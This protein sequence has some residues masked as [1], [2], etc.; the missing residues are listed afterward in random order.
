MYGDSTV[1][2]SNNDSCGA[3]R[4]QS[5]TNIA[6]ANH[7]LATAIRRL[8]TG[9]APAMALS[10][11]AASMFAI[12]HAYAETAASSSNDP[13][14]EVVV[15]GLRKS[16]QTSQELKQNSEVIQD[17]ISAVDIGALPDRSVT[18]AIQRIPG[19]TINHLFDPTD[20]NRFSAE[21]SGVAVRGMTQVRSELNGEDVFSARN[22][23]GLS[24]ED[25]PSELMAGVDVFKNP[26]ADMIEGGIGGTVNLRTRKPFDAKGLTG[27]VSASVNYGDFSKKT[28]PQAS[29]M[30]SDRW[31]TSIG[32]FG[33][34]LDVAYSDLATRTDSI[35]FGRPFRRK[36][37][38]VGATGMGV[39]G[40]QDMSNPGTTFECVFM[41][42]GARWSDLDFD[43]KRN[44]FDVALQWRPNDYI[45]T[46]LSVMQSDY[47][48][49][50]T[51]HSAW[52]QDGSWTPTLVPNTAATF[53]ANGVFRSGDLTTNSW[54]P[55]ND[56]VASI[57]GTPGNRIDTGATTRVAAQHQRTTNYS[58][59]IKINA[60]DR[61][62]LDGSV[63]YVNAT[64]HN[65]DYTVNTEV[66]PQSLQI[67]LSGD[68]PSIAAQPSDYLA[69]PA[70]YYWAAGMDDT[71][72]NRG[73]ELAA[74]LDLA[75]TLDTGWFKTLK[76]GLR[77]TNRGAENKDTG[78][79]W[80]QITEWWQG[81]ADG[82]WP[83][84]LATL[85]KYLTANS[86]YFQFSNFYRGK[87]NLPGGIWVANEDLV[88]NL[89]SNGA[90]IKQAE[91]QS[92]GWQ[93]DSFQ[94]G[95]TNI[96]HELTYAGYLLLKFGGDVGELPVDGN[97]G[98]RVVGTYYDASGAA[99]QPNWNDPTHIQF[100]GGA[101]VAQYGSG[102]WVPISF[103]SN[104]VD[105]LPS[106]NLR[107]K[108][109]DKLQWRFAA[110]KA[111]TRPS[112]D[113]LSANVQLNGNVQVTYNP[114]NSIA[115]ERVTGFTG[116]GGNPF[117][118]PMSAEQYDTALEWYFA[119]QGSLTG[120][121]F[122]KDLTNYFIRGTQSEP[123]FGTNW[124]VTTTV[125]GDHGV[126]KGF[127]LG[128]S[129]FYD[130]LPGFLKGLGAQANFTYIDSHGGSP[131]AGPT[132]DT[133]TVPPG[134]P[135]E[136]LSR[137]S[138]NLVAMYQRSIVEAR[139][140]YNWRKRWLLTT[141][142][143]DGKG[144]V[145]N[146]D[147][148]QLDGSL[149]FHLNS[150]LQIGLEANNLN[151]AKQKLLVG[152]FTYTTAWD[153]STPAYNV[154]YTDNRLYQNAWY[155]FDRRYALSIKYTF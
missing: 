10:G 152:P 138:Y 129:Q 82:T 149:F 58:W 65:T 28:K 78:Y 12:P 69:N 42:A 115:G 76:G 153:S 47:K 11:V 31:D 148:G 87:T 100:L 5:A 139:L 72:A 16:V 56:Y 143:G 141:H 108:F 85:D 64:A 119:P 142:D 122:Y 123:W 114:D 35:Q 97:I 121:A 43:R 133:A 79:N 117:L 60:T 63:V 45:E 81:D 40:C 136:G 118:K 88:K 86:T 26:S 144:S 83:G 151:N 113:Q 53:D 75:Y 68:L 73:S 147:F 98:M 90:I 110:S 6:H 89:D 34:L 22:T 150:H 21:G 27:G 96:Q 57:L 55:G 106:L 95:D 91:I 14:E 59:D 33:A 132:G 84:H 29:F 128:Y 9:A 41:P 52:F 18:E 51:E 112:F 44:G 7:R 127:E 109:T 77:F 67:D 61:L 30:I 103:K 125:N 120:T 107:I 32:E 134:L 37:S 49:D 93:P 39:Q 154:G 80:K 15:T 137:S 25:V 3:L 23:R 70:N 48:M 130:S 1:T 92:D 71:Q 140:A 38:D 24:F 20:T 62:S 116:T 8:F 146:D 131:T 145:W 54:V 19:V 46:S 94:P 155:T 17:S 13:L 66:D 74:K 124:D 101:F 99:Q 4:H 105:A 111:I 50:W 102:Q 135:L 2:K 126:I 104:Y 36:A